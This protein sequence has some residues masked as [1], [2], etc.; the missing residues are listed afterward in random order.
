MH[1]TDKWGMHFH[2]TMTKYYDQQNSIKSDKSPTTYGAHVSS[3]NK[4]IESFEIEI[5]KLRN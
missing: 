4:E 1:L 2:I 5:E 3:G